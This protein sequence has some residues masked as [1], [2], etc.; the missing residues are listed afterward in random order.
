MDRYLEELQNTIAE[1][2]SGMTTEQLEFHLDGKW[3]AAEV[4]EHLYL[5]Y[6]GTAKACEHCL[7]EGKILARRPVL[8]DRIR[9]SVVIGLGYMPEGREAPERSRPRGMA[10]QEVVKAIGQEI[11]VMEAALTRCEELFGAR[12]RVLDHPVLGP[13]TAR[14]W[15]KFHLVHGRHHVKQIWA[16]RNENAAPLISSERTPA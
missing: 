5:T 12:A 15:R 3:S 7:Q 2:I 8:Q 4:L 6:R 9:A 13:L 16:L 11:A 14:Q 1:A 10:T